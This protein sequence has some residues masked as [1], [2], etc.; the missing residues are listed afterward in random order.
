[1]EECPKVSGRPNWTSVN[2]HVLFSPFF[3]RGREDFAGRG[4]GVT[5][6]GR[7]VIGERVREG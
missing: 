3:P 2:L 1:M 7:D 6:A 4:G 5:L